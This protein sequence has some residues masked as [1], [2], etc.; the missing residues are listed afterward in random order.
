MDKLPEFCVVSLT[1]TRKTHFETLSD[2]LIV[3]IT[4]TTI[5]DNVIILDT[6]HDNRSAN[7]INDQKSNLT[8]CM[9]VLYS[10]M[11]MVQQQF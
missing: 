4:K 2:I 11:S 7:A 10:F 1:S 9:F 3:N 6:C 8:Y 5:S